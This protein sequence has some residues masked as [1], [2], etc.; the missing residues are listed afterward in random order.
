LGAAIGTIGSVVTTLLNAWLA[1]KDKPDYFD[2]RAM[3]VL[4]AVLTD[5][6]HPWHS[7]K[8]L[9]GLVGLSQ[10]DTS[11]ILLVIG[12]RGHVSGSGGWAPI[13]RVGTKIDQPMGPDDD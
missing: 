6:V 4:K 7:L 12:G 10:P 2:R 13:S 1:N 5:S 9:S 3:K 11:Q 8:T